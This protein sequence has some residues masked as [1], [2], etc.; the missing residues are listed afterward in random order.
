MRR[1]VESLPQETIDMIV[2]TV[3]QPLYS[4]DNRFT[5]RHTN[6][7]VTLARKTLQTLSLTSP[8]FRRQC[9]VHLFRKLRVRNTEDGGR[10]ELEITLERWSAAPE[11]ASFVRAVEVC[12]DF[13]SCRA[14]GPQALRGGAGTTLRRENQGLLAK[15]LAQVHNIQE[16]DFAHVPLFDGN[17]LRGF[18]DSEERRIVVKWDG[19]RKDLRKAMTRMLVVRSGESLKRFKVSGFKEVPL[20]DL[21]SLKSL[22]RLEI[23][24]STMTFAVDDGDR[25][26]GPAQTMELPWKLTSLNAASGFTVLGNP[27]SAGIYERLTEL[28]L[29]IGTMEAN[30]A[31]WNIVEG[32]RNTLKSLK[33]DYSPHRTQPNLSKHPSHSVAYERLK[34]IGVLVIQIVF[35][36]LGETKYAPR[37]LPVCPRL[38]ELTI[39]IFAQQESARLGYIASVPSSIPDLLS[40]I[41]Q[42]RRFPALKNFRAFIEAQVSL[43]QLDAPAIKLVDRSLG[44]KKLD[45]ILASDEELPALEAMKMSVNPEIVDATGSQVFD[46]DDEELVDQM[47]DVLCRMAEDELVEALCKSRRRME[48]L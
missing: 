38:E 45:E 1:S 8:R 10:E 39:S 5:T 33:L 12:M 3:A 44:W 37:D 41:V 18:A 31:A 7:D 40:Y 35:D 16:I 20:R 13:R 11:L 27:L 28:R 19:I 17:D 2:D 14:L 15:V 30:S 47:Q 29:V 26:W 24:S 23:P 36:C 21:A 22:E 32:A 42:G 48:R 9:R 4:S 25:A 34:L 46:E 43:A 6:S